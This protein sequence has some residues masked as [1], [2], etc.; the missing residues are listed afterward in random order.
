[1]FFLYFSS[2]ARKDVQPGGYR[3]RNRR[4]GLCRRIGGR[5]R[6]GKRGEDHGNPALKY[7]A[8]ELLRT[9]P[10]HAA[11]TGSI[12]ANSCSSKS[13]EPV[14]LEFSFCF[15]KRTR[16][17]GAREST[18]ALPLH[19]GGRNC[20]FFVRFPCY[21]RFGPHPVRFSTSRRDLCLGR[22]ASFVKH[23]PVP[24][25]PCLPF[26]VALIENHLM[27]GDC[28]NVGCVPSKALIS[29]ARVANTVKNPEAYG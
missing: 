5:V 17:F 19:R 15:V 7:C 4:P 28:L 29:A 16:G 23:P 11:Q 21:P 18:V 25:P 1:M 2:F 3:R 22:F 24:P 8:Y 12:A 20:F 10:C 14:R 13:P 6:K 26:Q 9:N 27:G